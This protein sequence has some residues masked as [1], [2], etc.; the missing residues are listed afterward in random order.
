M[1]KFFIH[2]HLGLGDHLDC[3]GMVRYIAEHTE[4][5]KVA[6][7]SKSN[8][9]SMIDY[10]YR[11]TDSIEV[12]EIS[13]DDEYEDV[14]RIADGNRLLVVGH[15]FYPGKQAELSQDKNCWEFFYEQVQ[16]PHKVRY[17]Y[18]YVERDL[19]E[20]QRVFNKLNPDNEPYI[21]IHED[22][23]RGF[24]LDRDH[25]IDS[26]LKVIENDV[27]E[28]IFHFTKILEEAQEIHCMESSFK[29]LIDFYCEQDNI[30]YHDI[31]E[32]QPLGQHSSPK[33]KVI[34]YA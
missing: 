23:A 8:Y 15:Q 13:K 14:K 34:K 4:H 3:N 20:E 10:M 33:W 16:I 31:R 9:F 22:A 1:D 27:T 24:L 21:F 17:D 32:S 30:F 29:T 12:V 6:V 7:F 5:E 25:F 11:D 2:H 18:F 19:E 28:N 26:D